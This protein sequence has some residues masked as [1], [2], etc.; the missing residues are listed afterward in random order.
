MDVYVAAWI[1]HELLDALA[2]AHTLGHV[3]GKLTMSNVL[4]A[5][6]GAIKLGGFGAARPFDLSKPHDLTH[7]AP[8]HGN[9]LP[10]DARSDVFVAGILLGGSIRAN[11]Q[12]CNDPDGNPDPIA[13]R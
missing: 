1:A 2:H 8:E 7:T 11:G 9:G 4:L 6:D 10:V 12:A 13:S 3:H 5:G